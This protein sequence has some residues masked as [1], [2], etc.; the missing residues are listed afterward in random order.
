M[1]IIMIIITRNMIFAG[2]REATLDFLVLYEKLAF[3]RNVIQ[4][5]TRACTLG[6]LLWPGIH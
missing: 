5:Y 4:S 6:K 2:T 3:S 1:I